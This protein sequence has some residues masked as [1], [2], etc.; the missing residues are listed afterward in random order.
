MKVKDITK[1]SLMLFLVAWITF[2]SVF[3][4]YETTTQCAEWV[5]GTI[6]AVG[7]APMLTALLIGGVVV[8]GGVAVYKIATTDAEDYRNFASGIKQGFQEFVADR[9]KQIALE[10][11]SSLTDQEASDIGV[12]NAR[13]TV[14]N[15]FDNAITTTKNT[16]KNIT[17]NAVKYWNLYSKIIAEVSDVGISDNNGEIGSNTKILTPFYNTS[18]IDVQYNVKSNIGSKCSV[19][20]NKYYIQSGTYPVLENNQLTSSEY[21]ASSSDTMFYIPY[22][23]V[24]LYTS[25]GRVDWTLNVLNVRKSNL[26]VVGSNTLYSYYFENSSPEQGISYLSQLMSL[27]TIPFYLWASTPNGS[28]SVGPLTLFNDD[29]FVVSS[30]GVEVPDY[31]RTVS[32]TLNNTKFGDAIQSGRRQL[33]NNGDW[34]GS[35]FK[36]DSIPV[37]KVG[38]RENEGV[39]TGDI[40]WQIPQTWDD[41]FGGGLPFPNVVGDT[42]T[43]A[44][45]GR[46]VIPGVMP[47]DVVIDFPA[48]ADVQDSDDYPKEH[49]DEGEGEGEKPQEIP[50]KPAQDVFETQGGS[51]YPSAMDLTNIFPFCIPFDLIYLVEK[52]DIHGENAPVITIPI[53]YPKVM[54]DANGNDRYDVVI[55][56]SDF[57][58][59]RNIVRIFLLLGFII[60]LLKMTREL[61]RG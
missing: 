44:V 13:E 1:R 47:K 27:C 16:A 37:N 20:N 36:E 55:D 23:S 32:N 51:Y 43:I 61:I 4:A 56:F 60:G 29:A 49:P 10:Q 40:G 21:T 28:T 38:L 24:C 59:L 2:I 50:E 31:K 54:A 7:G 15:F 52:F 19:L 8:A 25:S 58:V 30:S 33:V 22:L 39:M 53:M 5:A 48:D 42:G 17:F 34:V 12:A 11:N 46:E 35:I 3:H 57:L 41:Y 45:P 26:Q 9:E 6:A 14:N 18:G